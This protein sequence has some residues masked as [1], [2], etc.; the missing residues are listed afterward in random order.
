MTKNFSK[1]EFMSK[2]GAD[3]PEEVYHNVV[4]VANQ[5]QYLRDYLNKPIKVNSAYRSPEHNAK[6]GGVP[7]SQHLLGKA[8]DIVVKD[9]PTDILYQYIEDA[10]SN[11][12]ML[13]GG[14]GLYDT[15]VHYDIRGTKARWDYR[16]K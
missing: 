10:I 3:M 1:S 7:K 9:M 12:E 16:K 8:A 6:V 2:C 13:Q 15:F 4:K 5:L 14:L 11:G